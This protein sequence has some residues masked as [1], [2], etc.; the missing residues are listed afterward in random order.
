MAIINRA[1]LKVKFKDGCIPTAK[2]FADFQPENLRG[3]NGGR[4][5]WR[6]PNY[7]LFSF[8]G[9]Y[10]FQVKDLR[11][12]LRANVIN[13]FDTIYVSDGRNND[14]FNTPAFT[15]FDAKSASV[16]FGQ[17]RRWSLSLQI[18]F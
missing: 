5:S 15:D 16:H 2:N 8:H 7:T 14:N 17:G 12:G 3:D 4:D 18:S 6:L 1:G 10:S 13:L 11:F 9:G